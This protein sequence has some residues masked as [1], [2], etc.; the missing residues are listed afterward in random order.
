MG[1]IDVDNLEPTTHAILKSNRTRRDR[2][3][4][5]DLSE[6]ILNNAPETEGHFI[7]IPRIL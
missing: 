4:K 3:L 6:E 7:T 2:D 5:S 1:E